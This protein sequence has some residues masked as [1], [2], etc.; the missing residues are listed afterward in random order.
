MDRT[1]PNSPEGRLIGCAIPDCLDKARAASP[2]TYVS[3]DEPPFLI[4]HGTDDLTVPFHQSVELD[5]ALRE[6]GV[7]VQFTPLE[8]TGHGG[9]LFASAS[10][11][12]EVL[13]FFDTHLKSPATSVNPV[14]T[15]VRSFTLEQN[16]P[17][18]FNPSTTI[19]Y[20]SKERV[21]S[22]C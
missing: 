12:Q 2:I 21:K 22:S 11:N 7:E 3:G 13:T 16:Y 9:G 20:Y 8:N 4:M 10:T 1:S 17:N 18:P 19:R 5:S 15:E 14:L 6:V